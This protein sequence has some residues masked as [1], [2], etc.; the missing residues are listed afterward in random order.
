VQAAA[1]ICGEHSKVRALDI[2]EVDPDRD[3]KEATTLAAASFVLSFAAG[4][5]RRATS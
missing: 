2:T 1:S 3:V 5:A 4:L